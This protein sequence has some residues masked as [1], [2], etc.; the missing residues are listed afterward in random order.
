MIF[1]LFAPKKVDFGFGC[2]PILSLFMPY[3]YIGPKKQKRF[4]LAVFFF[5][6]FENYCIPTNLT[7]LKISLSSQYV[8]VVQQK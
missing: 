5:F 4:I 6:F 3:S 1:F 7:Q 8:C 2:D